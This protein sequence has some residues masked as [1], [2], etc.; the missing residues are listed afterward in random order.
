MN[1]DFEDQFL[2]VKG[3]A[4][5]G[6]RLFTGIEALSYCVINNRKLNID[7]SD[8]QFGKLNH[9]VFNDF[10]SIDHNLFIKDLSV[11]PNLKIDCY[12]K[13][14]NNN[15]D[16]NIYDLYEVGTPNYLLTIIP[17]LFFSK[18]N[19][20]SKNQLWIKK[21][22]NNKYGLKHLF[23]NDNMAFGGDLINDLKSNIVIF[24]DFRPS[25]N[26]K[27]LVSKIRLKSVY[28]NELNMWADNHELS[29][30]HIG[31]HIRNS[32]KRPE[33]SINSFFK[34]LRENYANKKIFLSTD[35]SDIELFF[36]ENFKDN[37]LTYPKDLPEE[38]A[39]RGIHMWGLDNNDDNYKAK[40]LK[41]SVYDMWLLSKCKT[42][43]YQGNSSFSLFSKLL[44]PIKENCYDW[45]KFIK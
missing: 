8:G 25:L 16:K 17:E 45:Q 35:N 5:L 27:S 42:L 31:I 39:E 15:L 23:D 38:V 28:Q 44:H 14:W 12:P 26:A 40:M 6:N 3:C 36:K 11:I 29:E 21:N 4:G 24:A 20:K 9:N 7:W 22:I 18:K 41:D 43:F 2:I 13:L 1:Y 30:S 34:F 32:D 37:L 10:F 19:K 33:K